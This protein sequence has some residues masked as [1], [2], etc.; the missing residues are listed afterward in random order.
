MCTLT[1]IGVTAVSHLLWLVH[2]YTVFSLPCTLWLVHVYTVFSLLCTLWLVY[3]VH[4]GTLYTAHRI[5]YRKLL[6]LC[7]LHCTH[8][9]VSYGKQLSLAIISGSF[10]VNDYGKCTPLWTH[11][12]F[13][14]K[15]FISHSDYG[16]WTF[17]DYGAWT[18][19]CRLCFINGGEAEIHYVH[20]P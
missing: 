5:S 4:C 10:N 11:T 16:A 19:L 1:S 20:G 18:R 9:I 12:A 2:V 13:E 7:S 6:E 14:H 17:Y 15:V 3:C 8:P